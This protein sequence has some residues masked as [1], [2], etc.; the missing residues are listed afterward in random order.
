VYNLNNNIIYLY[1][2]DKFGYQWDN[3]TTNGISIH[4]MQ[5][6]DGNLSP[7]HL[8]EIQIN[9]FKNHM[10]KTVLNKILCNIFTQGSY[11]VFWY[12]I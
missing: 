1:N 7:K 2:D 11:D 3:T 9:V 5:I 8:I 6:T 4:N 10:G 12:F